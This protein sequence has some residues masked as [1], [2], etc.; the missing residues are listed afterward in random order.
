MTKIDTIPSSLTPAPTALSG[1][2]PAPR[3]IVLV[4]DLE[5]DTLPALH[6][7]WELA[8]A[9]HAH[10]LLLSLCTDSAQEPS[11]RRSL[12]HMAAMVQD[13]HV[14]AEV[15]VEMESSWVDAVKRNHQP[16]DTIVCFA[17]QRAGL[18]HRPL[19][20]ILQSNLKIP[21]YILSGLY[22]P[23]PKWSLLPQIMAWLGFLG[24][25]TGFFLL[26]IN[27]VQASKGGMQSILLI[28]S[29]IPEYWLIIFWNSLLG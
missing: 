24:I 27:I 4:P 28:F 5:A 2:E 8:N 9:R 19:S 25:L 23:K 15:K 29:L 20:Q 6:R 18:L 21:V 3:L 17:E 26:Q 12:I 1:L 16:G 14:L 10:V 22:Q 11:L 13:G 7:I